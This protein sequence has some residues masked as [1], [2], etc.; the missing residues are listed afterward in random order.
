LWTAKVEYGKAIRTHDT[1]P[2]S[3]STPASDGKV[4]VVWHASA[5]LYCYDHAG[6]ELWKRDLGEIDH[7]WG[8][9]P[10][11]I[12][13]NDLVFLNSGPSTKRVFVG[14][15]KLSSG[16]TV[17]EKEEPYKGNGDTNEN[18]KYMGSWSTPLFINHQGKDQVI[19]SLPTRLAAYEP[20]TGALLWSC[21]GLRFDKGDLSYSSPMVAGDVCVSIGGFEGP[22]IGVTLGGS[23]DIT[24]TS[25]VWRTPRNPQSIGT[26]VVVDG[27]IYMPFTGANVIECIEPKTG[28]VLWKERATGAEIWGSM[29]YAAGHIY[30]TDK[31]GKTVVIKPNP[32]KLE[33]IATNDLGETANSTPAVSNGEIFIRTFKALYCIAE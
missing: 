19:V 24:S 16:E 25:R 6:K 20:K 32:E 5:G 11:P 9:G 17:W 4:V 22:G 8:E 23:G 27:R 18:N 14:A 13:H 7:M 1:N 10:S 31:K 15:Y 28:K 26:G 2:P 30:V 29:T 12:I 33:V 3:P 21:E